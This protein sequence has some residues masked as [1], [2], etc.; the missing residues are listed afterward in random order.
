MS[1]FLAFCMTL[2]AL[3][4]S[5]ASAQTQID[6]GALVVD[7]GAAIEVTS[8]TLS[9]DQD[10]GIAVFTGDVLVIQ[11]DLRLS[12]QRVEVVYGSDTD[13][14]ARL[15]ASGD[16]LLAN[17]QDA[18]EADNADYDITTGL[19]TLTGDVLVTQGGT[20]ISAQNMVVNVTDGTA[21][22]Q[23]R[24]RTMLQQGATE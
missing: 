12:A 22:M 24:V 11:G 1:R 14:I 2:L 5:A 23:G 16:V 6:L 3:L 9:V 10:T 20:V 4:S 19:L 8:Q 18:A 15:I 13:E 17:S 7:P 21:T